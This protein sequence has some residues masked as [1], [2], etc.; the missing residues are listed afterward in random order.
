MDEEINNSPI[1]IVDDDTALLQALPQVV[2]LRMKNV[3]VETTDSAQHALER[4]KE[5]DF[6][7]I[8]SDVKMPGID[9]IEL[10]SHIRELR[11][12][13]P[14][15]LIT[16]HGDHGLAIQ[17]IRG[18]AYDYILKP[19]DRDSF[20]NALQRAIQTRHLR[21]K[22][23]EQQL[24]LALHAKSLERLV[25]KRTSELVAANATKDKFLDIV[26]QELKSPLSNLKGMTQLMRHQLE[27]GDATTAVH[28]G[29][30]DMERSITR[31]EVL[32]QDLLDTSLMETNLFVLKRQRYNLVD[33]CRQLLDEYTS[34]AVLSLNCELLG[35]PIEAEVDRDR[36]SQVLI[37]LLSNARKF[38]KKGTA[39][40]ITVQQSG[41]EVI[42]SIH[43]MGIGIPEEELP[44]IFE[45]FYRVPGVEI[46]SGT[47]TGLGL[48]LFIARKIVE[49]HGGHI[50]VQ[51][52]LGQGSVFSVVLPVYVD[53]ANTQQAEPPA[54]LHTQAVWTIT[55]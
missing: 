6:D 45:Q 29:L 23:T 31:T 28:Q 26:S 4:I 19:I 18:G 36:F 42:V 47:R 5:Y 27:R 12:D 34:R 2:D 38:S 24:A 40:T 1:L 39:I 41:Y 35:D 17:A 30:V 25:E 43:D 48:G 32:V 20:I 33:L 37:N 16:G 46:Q 52:V 7:A 8:I 44:H 14:V 21:R 51:T 50:E 22:V 13:T 15:L 10:L 54:S 3:Q 53:P 11:P 55:H 49:R 9:G